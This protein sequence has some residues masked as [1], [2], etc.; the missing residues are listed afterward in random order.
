LQDSIAVVALTDNGRLNEVKQLV[1]VR[2]QLKCVPVLSALGETKDMVAMGDRMRT[3]RAGRCAF[4][5]RC[6]SS[7]WL[8][9]FDDI[10]LSIIILTGLRMACA[11][12]VA[13]PEC[14]KQ[15]KPAMSIRV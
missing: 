4:L 7:S 14:S 10:I 5:K 15:L 13:A 1:A 8:Q 11:V 9:V 6:P 3:A 2:A 12:G